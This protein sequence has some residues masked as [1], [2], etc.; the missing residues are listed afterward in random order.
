LENNGFSALTLC[1]NCL[2]GSSDN[3][4]YGTGCYSTI[5]G[6]RSRGQKKRPIEKK[7]PKKKIF[8]TGVSESFA[9]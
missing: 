7:L 8:V 2:S 6:R 9:S 3:N 4:A 5:Y 1:I